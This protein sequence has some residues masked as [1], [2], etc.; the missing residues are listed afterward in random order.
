[1]IFLHVA[2]ICS[3]NIFLILILTPAWL[4]GFSESNGERSQRNTARSILRN[5]CSQYS[6]GLSSHWNHLRR[7]RAKFGLA[8]AIAHVSVRP[9]CHPGR[10]HLASP[11]GDH[12]CPCAIFPA[13]PWLKR[14][15]AYTPRKTGLP[16]SSIAVCR[17]NNAGAESGM[18]D[19]PPTR[20]GRE[21]L[22]TLEVL[23]PG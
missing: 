21:P 12:D 10:S 1:M 23:P 4:P 16:H 2:L 22:S 7:Q 5:R 9:P 6:I 11:V 13:S 8:L 15:L 19:T 17:P 18:G 20:H 3:H 14:S